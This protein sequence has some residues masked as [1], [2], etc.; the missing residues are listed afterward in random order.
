MTRRD[1]SYDEL[2]G[3][4]E[5]TAARRRRLDA[6]LPAYRRER[7]RC[8]HEARVLRRIGTPEYLIGPTGTDDEVAVQRSE[9]IAFARKLRAS[10]GSQLTRA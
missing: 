6:G 10:A 5:R 2:R 8:E 1:L 4:G 3:R 7:L 9:L